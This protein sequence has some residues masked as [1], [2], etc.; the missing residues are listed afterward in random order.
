MSI[1]T[2]A[3]NGAAAV[4]SSTMNALIPPKSP[5]G[6]EKNN[7]QLNNAGQEALLTLKNIALAKVANFTPATFANIFKSAFG[8]DDKPLQPS[9]ADPTGGSDGLAKMTSVLSS[10]G[11]LCFIA[12]FW[13]IQEMCPGPIAGKKIMYILLLL[14]GGGPVGFIYLVLAFG[15]KKKVC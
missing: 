3:I 8:A 11:V 13:A 15:L 12:G 9:P 6:E 2:S 7:V 10:I 1:A 4:A 5:F 14:F